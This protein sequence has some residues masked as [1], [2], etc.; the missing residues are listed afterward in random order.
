[1]T[2]YADFAD[3]ARQGTS[4]F[5]DLPDL[6]RRVEHYRADVAA[7]AGY[8]PAAIKGYD[9]AER[10]RGERVLW[11]AAEIQQSAD[12]ARG[13]AGGAKRLM[14]AS[15]LPVEMN[16]A[17]RELHDAALIRFESGMLVQDDDALIRLA[18][19]RCAGVEPRD[20][21]EIAI[22][23]KELARRGLTEAAR[24]CADEVHDR[25]TRYLR[26]PRYAD[27]CDLIGRW[28][29]WEVGPVALT[30]TVD[31]ETFSATPEELMAP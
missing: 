30:V 22:V 3:A 27:A 7:G 17:T 18:A 14:E 12:R 28:E 4:D 23:E 1:M 5:P 29:A 16:A 24:T 9:H 25:R 15:G 6:L 13:R 19:D 11:L 21:D 31:G 2:T 10:L 8:N 26:D 20:Y